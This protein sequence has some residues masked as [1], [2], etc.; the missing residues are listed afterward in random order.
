MS[1][2]PG[3]GLFI[4]L[5]S[6]E[7]SHIDSREI[8]VCIWALARCASGPGYSLFRFIGL[9]TGS[10]A[11]ALCFDVRARINSLRRIHCA[12]IVPV[13]VGFTWHFWG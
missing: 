5:T 11:L 13:V 9:L 7:D 3:K 2:V 8:N 6:F 10:V 4:N 1:F 12:A